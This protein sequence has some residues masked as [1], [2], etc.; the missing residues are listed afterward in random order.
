MAAAAG[1]SVVPHVST[2]C[3][4]Q[5]AAALTLAAAVPNCDLVEYNPRVLDWAN[6]FVDSPIAV[7]GAAYVVPSG[8]GLGLGAVHPPVPASAG[9]G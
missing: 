7:S 4:P 8:P 9:I 5:I 2:A 1:A 3:G 6:R